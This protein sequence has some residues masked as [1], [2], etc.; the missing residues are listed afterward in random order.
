[1]DLSVMIFFQ[2]DLDNDPAEVNLGK[3]SGPQDGKW[4]TLWDPV[5]ETGEQYQIGLV[6]ILNYCDI[7][8][9]GYNA[10]DILTVT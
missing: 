10:T 9:V 5:L 2:S 6:A 3:Q 1:M 4:S 8:N 7:L